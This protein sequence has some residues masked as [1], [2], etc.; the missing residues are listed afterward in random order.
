MNV[1][2]IGKAEV[3]FMQKESVLNT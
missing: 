2:N 3:G 1:K